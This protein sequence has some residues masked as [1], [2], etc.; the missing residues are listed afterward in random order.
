MMQKESETNQNYAS[1]ALSAGPNP[2]AVQQPKT[3]KPSDK[4]TAGIMINVVVQ[5]HKADLRANMLF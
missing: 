4:I 2:S 1:T 3:D 5:E